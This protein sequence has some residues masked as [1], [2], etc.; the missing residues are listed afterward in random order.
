MIFATKKKRRTIKLLSSTRK[1]KTTTKATTLMYESNIN[2]RILKNKN[3]ES[4]VKMI[5][6]TINRRKIKLLTS[7]RKNKK[8]TTQKEPSST[9]LPSNYRRGR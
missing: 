6:A 7:S 4:K 2:Y 9:S 3:N 1:S 8:T 5:F